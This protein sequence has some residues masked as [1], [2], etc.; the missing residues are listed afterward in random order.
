LGYGVHTSLKT[1]SNSYFDRCYSEPLGL[2]NYLPN[3]SVRSLGKEE[4]QK[5][6]LPP[7]AKGRAREGLLIEFQKLF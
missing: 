1:A 6:F 5:I 2:G 7:L 4:N 3:C